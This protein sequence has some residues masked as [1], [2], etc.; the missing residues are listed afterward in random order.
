V[1]RVEDGRGGSDAI[2]V[3]LDVSAVNGGPIVTMDALAG[4]L[5]V[6]DPVML[7]SVASDPDGA[8][9]SVKY[10]VDGTAIGSGTNSSAGW[11]VVW[12][13]VAAGT[14]ALTGEATDNKGKV[15][16]RSAAVNVTVV[17]RGT[18]FVA[19]DE[20]GTAAPATR[21]G[22]A[23]L[24][25]EDWGGIQ[26]Y[27][28][29][30]KLLPT[31]TTQ[32]G[33]VTWH[34]ADAAAVWF[35]YAFTDGQPC[36]LAVEASPDGIAFASVS[37]FSQRIGSADEWSVYDGAAAALPAGTNFVRV[38]L[39]AVGAS[40]NWDAA[41][42][43]VQIDSVAGGGSATP[44][45]LP[46]D[47]KVSLMP[48]AGPGVQFQLVF[49]PVQSGWTY[50]PEFCT[51]LVAGNWVRLTAFTQADAGTQRTITDLS[52]TGPRRFYRVRIIPAP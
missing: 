7:T 32:V 44:V 45:A 13:P 29:G 9:A 19:T 15:G 51:D 36:T 50:T 31:G 5:V 20:C 21:V 11:G 3:D 25:A 43:W 30:T 18:V 1:V 17:A 39:G 23:G 47:F 40:R 49:G 46:A 6:G 26:P 14:Y 28:D 12:T 37:T 24:A 27:G 16:A 35:S 2:R 52:A 42:L 34:V 41:L 33:A 38:K 8:V 22:V 4:P 10:L 48:A